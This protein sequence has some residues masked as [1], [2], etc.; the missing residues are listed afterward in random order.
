MVTRTSQT[1]NRVE[2]EVVR[3]A[4]L[5]QSCFVTQILLQNYLLLSTAI[6]GYKKKDLLGMEFLLNFMA[7]KMKPHDALWYYVEAV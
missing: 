6:V 3:K 4:R 7:L 2:G 1:F 5:L